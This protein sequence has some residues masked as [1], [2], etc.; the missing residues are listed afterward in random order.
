MRTRL[1]ILT[2]PLALPAQH[3]TLT[4]ADYDR[5]VKMLGQNVNSLVVGGQVNP[6]WTPDGKFYYRAT[7][8]DGTTWLLVDPAKKKSGP[9]FDHTKLAAAVSSASGGSYTA[10]TLPFTALDHSAKGDSIRFNTGGKRYA[11]ALKTYTCAATGAA[12]AES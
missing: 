11:C 6:T 5:A 2:L 4:A 9:L 3:R 1:L 10:S 8:L 12:G 7:R